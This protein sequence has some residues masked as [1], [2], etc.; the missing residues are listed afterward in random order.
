MILSAPFFVPE[1]PMPNRIRAYST[2]RYPGDSLGVYEQFNLALHV[3]DDENHV[4]ANR[5]QLMQL[6]HLPSTP[7]WLNQTHSNTALLAETISAEV[8][9]NADASYTQKTGEVCVVMTAD[10]LPILIT[11]KEGTEVAAIHAGWQGLAKGVIENTLS[12]L[13]S[14]PE[15]LFIWIG[16][17]IQQASY[18]VGEDFYAAFA[19]SHTSQEMNATFLTQQHQKWLANVPLLAVQRLMRSGVLKDNIYLSGECTYAN[20]EKYFS[21]RRDGVTGR[22]A[23]LIWIDNNESP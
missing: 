10:C 12:K 18:E 13:S 21:Y 4:L 9:P 6:A 20:S 15:S 23:S 5:H 14:K 19:T 16:P 22:M 2:L 8:P 17:S 11:N 7:R 3:G 1:W